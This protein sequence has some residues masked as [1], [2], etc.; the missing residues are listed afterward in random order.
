MRKELE[1]DKEEQ[2]KVSTVSSLVPGLPPETNGRKLTPTVVWYSEESDVII[3]YLRTPTAEQVGTQLRENRLRSDKLHIGLI[4]VSPNC[5]VTRNHTNDA[6]V[7]Y[8]WQL[9]LIA[10]ELHKFR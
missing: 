8:S 5:N 7:V 9:Q 2:N 4:V 6:L 3:T 1:P 10:V